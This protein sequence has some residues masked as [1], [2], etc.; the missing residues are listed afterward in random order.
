MISSKSDELA[1]VLGKLSAGSEYDRGVLDVLSLL[2][3]AC[4]DNGQAA[5]AGSVAA[6]VIDSLHAHLTDGVIVDLRWSTLDAEGVRG[7]DIL[8]AMEISRLARVPRPTPARFVRAAQSVIKN[9][10]GCNGIA[11]DLYLMQYDAHAGRY[12]PVGGKYEPNDGDMMTTLRREMI[13]ELELPGTPE[14]TLTLLG[15]GWEETTLSATYG[16]LT[17]YTFSFYQVSDIDFQIEVDSITRWLT[18]SEILAGCASD[19]RPISPIYQHALGWELLDSL[20]PC[21]P[22][23]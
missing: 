11:E 23:T 19:G 17:Q 10:R 21:A 8:R 16:V 20:P 4:L 18:R 2:G 7:V 22:I 14:C 13:E 6:M 15:D 5:P 9:Y 12:Q 3:L 1:T